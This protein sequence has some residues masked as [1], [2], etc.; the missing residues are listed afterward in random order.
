M[1]RVEIIANH[2]VE[3][4]LFDLIEEEIEDFYYT[5]I[6]QVQGKGS[7]GPRRGDHIWPES[8]FIII[9][10]TDEETL[11]KLRAIIQKLK[12]MFPQE[13][14]KLFVTEA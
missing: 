12:R 7:S 10:Y 8:N 1:K 14:I 11:E 4:D 5:Q 3:E 9:S 6:P 2:S 13:G